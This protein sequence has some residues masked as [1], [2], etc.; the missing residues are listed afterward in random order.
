MGLITPGTPTNG[1]IRSSTLITFKK[2]EFEK[3][4]PIL[5]NLVPV[6]PKPYIVGEVVYLVL[7]LSKG[8]IPDNLGDA[9][10]S[11]TGGF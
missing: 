8:Q 11:L 4:M 1:D 10:F 7:P 6:P 5:S 2:T 3:L 9:V